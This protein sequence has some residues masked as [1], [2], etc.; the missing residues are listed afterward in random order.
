MY[1]IK[2]FDFIILC[3]SIAKEPDSI[4][5]VYSRTG[6]YKSQGPGRAGNLLHVTVLLPDASIFIIFVHVCSRDRT[7]EDDYVI[8][9][10]GVFLV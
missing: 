3:H 9:F 10:V 7:G 4:L 1:F 2:L 6:M 8:P 5:I